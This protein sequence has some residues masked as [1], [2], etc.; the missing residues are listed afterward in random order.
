MLITPLWR[1]VTCGNIGT[2]G[3]RQSAV[4]VQVTCACCD[5]IPP[6]RELELGVEEGFPGQAHCTRDPVLSIS[7]HNRLDSNILLGTQLPSTSRYI[8]TR[9][10]A[11]DITH[12]ILQNAWR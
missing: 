10:E 7:A 5:N 3:A 8:D 11:G 2:V 1:L 12:P 4:P 6:S 9:S